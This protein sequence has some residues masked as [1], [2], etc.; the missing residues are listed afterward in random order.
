MVFTEPRD[1]ARD[2]DPDTVIRVGF[3]EPLD[4]ASLADGVLVTRDGV[5]VPGV[6][7][8][9]DVI[10]VFTPDEPLDSN[11]EYVVALTTALRD[12]AGN[13]LAVAS[14]FAFE[15]GLRCRDRPTFEAVEATCDGLDND[16]DGAV[17]EPCDPCL[18]DRDH[19]GVEDCI[20]AALGTDPLDPASV[21]RPFVAATTAP[22]VL[23]LSEDV[24]R[25]SVAVPVS[26][27][28]EEEP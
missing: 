13:T 23:R 3:S 21:I 10:V 12:P 25:F 5:E 7:E 28:Y 2:V 17:D 14:A 24:Q 4:P 8:V 16:C 26:V 18:A 20:E 22:R 27:T 9:S 15:T 6:A 11:A 19:D 1:D